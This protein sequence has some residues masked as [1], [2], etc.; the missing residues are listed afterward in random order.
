MRFLTWLLFFA[1]VVTGAFPAVTASAIPHRCTGP[2]SPTFSD[3]CN[4]LETRSTN[5][6]NLETLNLQSLSKLYDKVYAQSRSAQPFE[7]VVPS[8]D[9]SPELRSAFEDEKAMYQFVNYWKRLANSPIA[10]KGNPFTQSEGKGILQEVLH[11]EG[12]P[13]IPIP[14]PLL[15]GSEPH[16]PISPVLQDPPYPWLE[17]D[18]PKPTGEKRPRESEDAEDPDAP[19]RKKQ[20]TADTA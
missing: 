3:N 19:P 9:S 2:L 10:P 4:R 6:F 12:L 15:K 13:S 1:V 18:E 8:K 11:S 7:A 20:K 5:L 16:R 17:P 14:R